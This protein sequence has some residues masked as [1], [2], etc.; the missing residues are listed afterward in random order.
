[1][2]K[3]LTLIIFG[4]TGDLYKNKIS[5]ALLDL[6]SQGLLPLDFSVVAFARRQFTDIEFRAFTKESL[7]KKNNHSPKEIE[8]FLEHFKYVQGNLGDLEDYKKLNSTLG[9]DDE[10][11]GVCTNKLFY[12]AVPPDLYKTIFE[13][14]SGSGLAYPCAEED[15]KDSAWT[16]VLVEKPFGKDFDEA[17]RL[18]KMLG[19]LF[20]ESQIFRIDHY[21]AKETVQNILTFRFSNNV[22]ESLWSNKYIERVKIVFHEK[23]TLETRG[24]FYDGVGA[25]RDVGQNHMLQMLAI[26]AMEDPEGIDAKRIRELRAEI[27]EKTKLIEKNSIVRAQYHGYLKEQGVDPT[28]K[29]ETFFRMILGINNERW[30]GI[31]FE[32]ESGKALI[33]S[34]VAIEVYFKETDKC[35]CPTEHEGV[36]QNVLTFVIQPNESIKFRFWFKRPGFEFALD[37]QD[38]SFNYERD[39]SESTVHDAYERVLYDCI[40]GDQTLFTNT[41]EVMAEWD[42]IAHIMDTWKSKPLGTYAKGSM[43]AD[44]I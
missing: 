22:F 12:L 15:T 7:L 26:I 32:L 23:N 24:D 18:D 10:K 9:V 44:I 14:I 30:E 6:F 16:R 40:R 36:H 38:L 33:E 19:E 20:D 8:L 31:P 27:L 13:N 3:P 1:M 29:T 21:L 28:S 25:L 11:R 5:I 42:L 17:Q 37:P 34:R 39:A 35:F 4:A 2:D 41:K 43:P